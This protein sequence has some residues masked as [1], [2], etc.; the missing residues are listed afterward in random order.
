[1]IAVCKKTSVDSNAAA[2]AQAESK[3]TLERNK[4]IGKDYMA[5]LRKKAVIE[6]R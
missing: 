6:Y 2:I 3:L 1:M 5:E 4:D